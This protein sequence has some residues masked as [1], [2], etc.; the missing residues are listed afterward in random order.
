MLKRYFG[1]LMA[2]LNTKLNAIFL[3]LSID[4][5]Q[6]YIKMVLVPNKVVRYLGFLGY[7]FK[8]KIKP[9]YKLK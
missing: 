7:F 1:S 3:G 4:F 6:I 5:W 2:S 9:V 8:V